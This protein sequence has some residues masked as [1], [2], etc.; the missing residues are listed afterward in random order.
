[1]RK[2]VSIIKKIRTKFSLN[3]M[4]K[5]IISTLIYNLLCYT[6]SLIYFSYTAQYHLPHIYT[7]RERERER[8]RDAFLQSF[9]RCIYLIIL[10]AILFA[11]PY[12]KYH[13]SNFVFSKVCRQR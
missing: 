4:L 9:K 8:E 3:K 6:Y 2:S 7:E 10:P 12:Y 1:M 5:K 11:D 13:P